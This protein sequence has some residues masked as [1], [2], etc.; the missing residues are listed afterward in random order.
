[1]IKLVP[2]IDF[3]LAYNANSFCTGH[4]VMEPLNLTYLHFCL[5]H[6]LFEHLFN[7]ILYLLKMIRYNYKI[8]LRIC[9]HNKT[10]TKHFKWICS[11][12]GIIS[13]SGKQNKDYCIVHET[14]VSSQS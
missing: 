7:F 6:S 5:Q 10:K 2:N 9:M 13:R 14:T 8:R 3:R 12:N 11:Q 1:M 4:F